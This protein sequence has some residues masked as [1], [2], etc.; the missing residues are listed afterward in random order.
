ML[1]D[2]SNDGTAGRD[3]AGRFV[4]GNDHGRGRPAGSRNNASLALDELAAGEAEGVLRATVA[5]AVAGD[6]QAANLILARI[7]PTRRGRPVRIDLPAIDTAADVSRALAALLVGV[8]EG[9]I[10]P[11]EATAVAGLLDLQRR[12]IETQNLEARIVALEEAEE[13]ARH[14]AGGID[15]GSRRG[16]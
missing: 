14:E 11:D 2:P 4:R 6:M 8:G 3:A 10:T 1:D 16:W 7:W 12:A 13:G 9:T 15:Y 5:A